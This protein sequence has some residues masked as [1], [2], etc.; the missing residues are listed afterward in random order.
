[1][2]SKMDE[3]F[4]NV[5]NDPTI[6]SPQFVIFNN[7]EWSKMKLDFNNGKN[8]LLKNTID[9]KIKNID[10]DP[11]FN[12]FKRPEQ[13][14]KLHERIIKT[15][16]EFKK[17]LTEA[18]FLFTQKLEYLDSFSIVRSNLTL[19][20]DDF[21]KVIERY[22]SSIVEQ[23]FIDKI[24]RIPNSDRYSRKALTKLLNYVKDLYSANISTEEIAYFIRKLKSLDLFW[25]LEI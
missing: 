3:N 10:S 16:N 21:G 1:M 14:R 20:L 6:F 23:F 22:N 13:Y 17:Y 12:R 9:Q 19:N 8:D 2:M 11:Q 7:E 24:S 18:R 4:R 25:N 15:L 5:L